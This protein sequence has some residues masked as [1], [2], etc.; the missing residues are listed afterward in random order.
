MRPQRV[1]LVGLLCGLRMCVA[2]ITTCIYAF[3]CVNT[4]DTC[5]GILSGDEEPSLSYHV[6]FPDRTR[7]SALAAR[8]CTHWAIAL[9]LRR[10]FPDQSPGDAD[11][12]M[13]RLHL[14]D[15]RMHCCYSPG[16][17]R[18]KPGPRRLSQL[19]WLT[20]DSASLCLCPILQTGPSSKTPN[21]HNALECSMKSEHSFQVAL[22]SG[23]GSPTIS[24]LYSL[25]ATELLRQG[26]KSCLHQNP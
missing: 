17:A 25:Q 6:C 8:A 14:E 22:R 12:A 4:M 2:L 10:A 7:S 15:T 9:V 13:Q 11:A 23:L 26:Y 19:L 18:S 3:E 20:Q 21:T 16:S 24:G 5:H 1:C